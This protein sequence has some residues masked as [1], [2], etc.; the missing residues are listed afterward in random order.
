MFSGFLNLLLLGS[1]IKHYILLRTLYFY[2]NAHLTRASLEHNPHR[3]LGYGMAF[4]RLPYLISRN[5]FQGKLKSL[6]IVKLHWAGVRTPKR[7]L[8][9]VPCVI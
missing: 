3:G 2:D 5:R 8:R 4:S 7:S 6:Y 1:L 9:W